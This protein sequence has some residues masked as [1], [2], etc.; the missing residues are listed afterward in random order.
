MEDIFEK[1]V[2]TLNR[3]LELIDT[4][5]KLMADIISYMRKKGTSKFYEY[6]KGPLKETMRIWNQFMVEKLSRS[7]NRHQ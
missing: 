5:P 6:F 7:I 2:T 3:K 1:G 4:S